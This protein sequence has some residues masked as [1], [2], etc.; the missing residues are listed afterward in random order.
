M[1]K[2]VDRAKAVADVRKVLAAL[3]SGR[4]IA[5]VMA[6]DSGG[7][8]ITMALGSLPLVSLL[9]MMVSSAVEDAIRTDR[10]Q[11]SFP[12]RAASRAN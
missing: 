4:D 8:V 3:E 7:S 5:L 12:Q 9:S 1:S 10:V 6:A 2:D 11:A